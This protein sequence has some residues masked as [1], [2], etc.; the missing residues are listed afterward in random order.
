[1]SII[2]S[3]L[4]SVIPLTGKCQERLSFKFTIIS[5]LYDAICFGLNPNGISR[6]VNGAISMFLLF[7]RSKSNTFKSYSFPIILTVTVIGY[8]NGFLNLTFPENSFPKLPIIVV[9]GNGFGGLPSP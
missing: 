1:M 6:D 7:Y 2:Y 4:D 8:L 3:D 5:Q 9:S